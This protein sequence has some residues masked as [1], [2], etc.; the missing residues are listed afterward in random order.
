M[1]TRALL[2]EEEVK[3]PQAFVGLLRSESDG[4]AVRQE[5]KSNI[6][7]VEV[8]RGPFGATEEIKAR[9]TFGAV[10][11]GVGGASVGTVPIEYTITRR[12]ELVEFETAIYVGSA[13]GFGR[14][15]AVSLSRA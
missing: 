10:T 9:V 4:G 11:V 15:E 12:P 3:V 6:P 8:R 2:E 13:N 1:V 7:L 14:E 5:K